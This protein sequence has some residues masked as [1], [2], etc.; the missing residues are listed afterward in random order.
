MTDCDR[1]GEEDINPKVRL[2]HVSYQGEMFSRMVSSMEVCG[3]CHAE[4]KESEKWDW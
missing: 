4:M 1:C 3:D 2:T